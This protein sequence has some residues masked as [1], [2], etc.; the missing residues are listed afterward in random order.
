M[1]RGPAPAPRSRTPPSCATRS[2][3]APGPAAADR[4]APLVRSPPEE[5]EGA[6]EKNGNRRQDHGDRADEAL[7]PPDTGLHR[8]TAGFD[9]GVARQFDV[10]LKRAQLAVLGGDD[11]AH[12][13][14][15]RLGI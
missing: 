7:Q 5:D 6:D 8:F 14:L 1:R 9:T 4:G 2:R 12:E 3:R 13:D 15:A 10:G 11:V